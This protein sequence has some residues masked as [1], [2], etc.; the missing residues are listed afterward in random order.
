MSSDLLALFTNRL[1]PVF[2]R[3]TWKFINRPIGR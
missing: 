2:R 1:M 3:G